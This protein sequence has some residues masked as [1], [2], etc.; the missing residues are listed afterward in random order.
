MKLPKVCPPSKRISSI[1]KSL[2]QPLVL[3]NQK[4]KIVE[5][6]AKDKKITRMIVNIFIKAA[7]TCTVGGTGQDVSYVW[8]T[9]GLRPIRTNQVEMS[10]CYLTIQ[11]SGF[12]KGLE[13]KLE[14]I[15]IIKSK[16]SVGMGERVVWEKGQ[17]SSWRYVIGSEPFANTILSTSSLR[18]LL[19]WVWE[20][21]PFGLFGC[22]GY[23]WNNIKYFHS[24][25]FFVLCIRKN[26]KVWK[27]FSPPLQPISFIYGWL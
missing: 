6:L 5:H 21:Y 15:D 20:L 4:K 9:L 26:K 23:F 16:G 14:C 8:D 17:D 2:Y 10:S 24:F 11:G 22:G 13:I 7:F 27:L 25:Q 12:Q 3:R 19:C 1:S 18:A